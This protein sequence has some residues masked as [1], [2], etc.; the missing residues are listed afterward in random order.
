MAVIFGLAAGSLGAA[1]FYL[2]RVFQEKEGSGWQK[3]AA[4]KWE[5]L[6]HAAR[7]SRSHLRF[8]VR[9]LATNPFQ[10]LVGRDRLG[11]GR[12]HL[13][14][15]VILFFGLWTG[16]VFERKLFVYGPI[17][18]FGSFGLH[19]LVK[20]L[21]G[22][23]ACRRLNEDKRSGALELL[24]CTPIRARSI[25]AGQMALIRRLYI[26]PIV[27]LVFLNFQWF[28]EMN[29]ADEQAVVRYAIWVLPLDC[30]ALAWVGMLNALKGGSYAGTLFKSVGLVMVPPWIMVLLYVFARLTGP[31][32]SEERQAFF[33]V[34]FVL[35][36]GYD[37]ILA[38]WA[39]TRLH[40]GF[41]SLAA[42]ARGG[43]GRG[44]R[45]GAPD[46][47]VLQHPAAVQPG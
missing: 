29:S 16:W 32:S 23:E 41:R 12:L 24:L 4:A 20:T 15:F 10:W 1:S 27:A 13:L 19:L 37:L 6:R 3:R 14:T 18:F 7:H 44:G 25:L 36:A 11:W 42:E 43:N 33:F 8:R 21:V 35:S 9:M 46:A 22:G 47:L 28:A 31:S 17:V 34:W 40:F 26:L 38:A 39:G 5:R 2:P 45:K 30:Y